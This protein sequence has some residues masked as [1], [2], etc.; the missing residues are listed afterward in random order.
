MPLCLAISARC[1]ISI[2]SFSHVTIG[3]GAHSV[4]IVRK[5]AAWGKHA[6]ESSLWL[7]STWAWN[8][9][10]ASKLRRKTRRIHKLD[11]DIRRW[12]VEPERWRASIERSKDDIRHLHGQ[13]MQLEMA[14]SIKQNNLRWT[15]RRC[16]YTTRYLI[17]FHRHGGILVSRCSSLIQPFQPFWLYSRSR[18]SFRDHPNAWAPPC[19]S[20]AVLSLLQQRSRHIRVYTDAILRSCYTF[21]ISDT[22]RVIFY[23]RCHT[24][25]TVDLGRSLGCPTRKRVRGR[26]SI[27]EWVD[28]KLPLGHLFHRKANFIGSSVHCSQSGGIYTGTVSDEASQGSQVAESEGF[29]STEFGRRNCFV[30]AEAG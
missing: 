16:H 21:L 15:Q 18:S 23:E 12:S 14:R 22:R 10:S 4:S 24:L 7:H 11:D 2:R 3:S 27:R 8:A 5:H 19:L 30:L 13:I 1:A 28:G 6:A 9:C 20:T 17:I 26:I 29:T 25:R